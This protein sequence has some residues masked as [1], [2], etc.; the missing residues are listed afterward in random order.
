M[1]A[2]FWRG[3]LL[4]INEYFVGKVT[5]DLFIYVP[6]LPGF[7]FILLFFWFRFCF[8]LF[9]FR[10]D[11]LFILGVLL[12]FQ[13]RLFG[14]FFRLVPIRFS[15]GFFIF[16]WFSIYFRLLL[17]VSDHGHK[18]NG[19]LLLHRSICHGRISFIV[20]LLWILLGNFAVL[21]L[22]V[23]GSWSYTLCT[24]WA[25]QWSRNF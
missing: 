6:G 5:T 25:F 20:F 21:S 15:L 10:L 24:L 19:M 13:L 17:Y 18:L 4:Q 12:L 1:I 3:L 16:L 2:L 11:L 9:H 14:C 7:L 22:S 23:I 8:P